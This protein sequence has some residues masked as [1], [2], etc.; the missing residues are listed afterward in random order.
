[1]A[2]ISVRGETPTRDFSGAMTDISFLL[3]IFFI[4]SAIFV[5]DQGIL[6]KLPDPETP[7]R[8]LRKDQVVTIEITEPGAYTVDGIQTSPTE[9]RAALSQKI[10]SFDEPIVVL[11]VASGVTYQEVLAVLEEARSVGY[12]GFSLAT[13]LDVP[14]GLHL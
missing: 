3:I 1:M 10:G 7:P 9:L 14:V 6:L 13:D 4:V 12:S 5:T 8:T 2:R 11:I